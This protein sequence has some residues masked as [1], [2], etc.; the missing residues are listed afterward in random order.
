MRWLVGLGIAL[1]D[2]CASEP[3]TGTAP[4]PPPVRV[5]DTATVRVPDAVRGLILEDAG[6][7]PRS[8]LRLRIT[9]RA[10][11]ETTILDHWMETRMHVLVTVERGSRPDLLEYSFKVHGNDGRP[12]ALGTVLFDSL[13]PISVIAW[14]PRNQ[15][16]TRFLQNLADDTLT[17]LF[18]P[19]PVEEV[20]VGATWRVD[21]EE[22]AQWSTMYR[23]VERTEAG[24]TIEAT[25]EARQ[26]VDGK[27]GPVLPQT[28]GRELHWRWDEPLPHAGVLRMRS[29]EDGW[30]VTHTIGDS[31]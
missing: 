29:T 5:P 10:R 4:V 9:R 22:G 24:F 17:D 7:E 31:G 27:G 1:L 26:T 14:D 18:V 11:Q 25:A 20:G 30:K 3:A 6:D 8:P 13:G 23:L 16:E 12:R 2:I 28:R 15:P 19:F 21:D